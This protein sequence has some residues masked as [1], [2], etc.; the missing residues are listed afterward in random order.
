[1]LKVGLAGG[2]GSGKSL[3]SQWFE[4]QGIQVV[5]ADIVARQI[6]EPGSPQL[7]SISEHFGPEILLENGSLN[8][9]KLREIIFTE[10]E[11]KRW[12]EALLHPAIRKEIEHQLNTARST[13]TMLASPLLFETDQ[14]QLVDRSIVVDLPIEMQIARASARDS[15]KSEQIKSIIDSQMNRE[16]RRARADLIIDNSGTI[17]ET[18][19]QCQDIYNELIK[20]SVPC[21]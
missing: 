4:R 17:N 19:A 2:I 18:Y 3:V 1:M 6:V 10:A 9:A 8:R 20:S 12:L 11:Q 5:D 14:Y 15:V 13:F 16:E 7:N 21:Q